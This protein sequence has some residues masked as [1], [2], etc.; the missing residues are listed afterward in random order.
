MSII[1]IKKTQFKTNEFIKTI[2]TE[3]R[4]LIDNI[5]TGN[6]NLSLATIEDFFTLYDQFFFE[7][8][9]EGSINSHEFI[10]KKS[11][12]YADF[13]IENEKI[14]ALLEEI[15]ILRE[16]NLNLIETINELTIKFTDLLKNKNS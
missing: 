9:K 13:E 5:P 10:I 11:I 7:I 14:D 12:E 16:E 2:D 8:P 1:P 6:L 15:N 3:F 4:E